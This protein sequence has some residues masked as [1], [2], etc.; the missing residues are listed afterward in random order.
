MY[1]NILSYEGDS[2]DEN[3]SYESPGFTQFS[4]EVVCIEEVFSG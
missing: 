4:R 1:R 2:S 3:F